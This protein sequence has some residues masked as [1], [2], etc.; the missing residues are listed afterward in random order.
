M[1]TLAL[2]FGSQVSV[3]QRFDDQAEEAIMR[4]IVT[5]AVTW[6]DANEFENGRW[7]AP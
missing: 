6:I 1:L 5:F 7:P 4:S 2:R 3:N